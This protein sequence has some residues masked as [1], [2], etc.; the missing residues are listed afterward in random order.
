MFHWSKRPKTF[1]RRCT[2][3][4][5]RYSGKRKTYSPQRHRAIAVN[6]EG[7]E[8]TTFRLRQHRQRPELLRH[9][10][11][12]SS[13]SFKFCRIKHMHHRAR[14]SDYTNP[15]GCLAG[16]KWC[17]RTIAN[18]LSEI[19]LYRTVNTRGPIGVWD[20]M[21]HQFFQRCNRLILGTNNFISHFT[22]HGIICPCWD[23]S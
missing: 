18:F 15:D 4:W 12:I 23:E 17:T 22:G 20:E 2:L 5:F 8:L 16:L 1:C 6:H 21:T 11:V 7:I 9:S 3:F 14:V 19:I 10:V 13:L